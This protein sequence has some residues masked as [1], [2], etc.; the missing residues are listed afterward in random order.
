MKRVNSK[1]WIDCF[2]SMTQHEYE[3]KSVGELE[4]IYTDW[5]QERA[6]KCK[7]TEAKAADYDRLMSGGKKTLKELANSRNECRS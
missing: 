2:N 3:S 5:L 4:D 7:A 1:L 6:L